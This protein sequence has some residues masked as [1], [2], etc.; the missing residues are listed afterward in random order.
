MGG[1]RLPSALAHFDSLPDSACVRCEVVQ[2][3]FGIS[4]TTVVRWVASGALPQ[5]RRHGLRT[6]AWN[7]GELRRVLAQTE[8]G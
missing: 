2:A 8:G 3:L 5:P 7:V 1:K 4:R 6:T